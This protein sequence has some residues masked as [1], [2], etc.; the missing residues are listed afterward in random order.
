MPT[1]WVVVHVKTW[2]K[3]LGY[4]RNYLLQS[5]EVCA[6]FRSK[7]G[8]QFD[9]CQLT[10]CSAWSTSER[11]SQ[12]GSKRE[13][14]ET[15]KNSNSPA[16]GVASG[17]RSEFPEGVR[18]DPETPMI[19]CCF[20]GG[21]WPAAARRD[22]RIP[23]EAGRSDSTSLMLAVR[24]LSLDWRCGATAGLVFQT[25]RSADDRVE[26]SYQWITLSLWSTCISNI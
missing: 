18:R 7:G 8:F 4:G 13:E 21:V 16:A 11:L 5:N 19:A 10:P 9:V 17:S 26:S 2:C 14:R 6:N 3:S 23:C 1:L 20:R 15:N 22:K 24:A 12:H 25:R